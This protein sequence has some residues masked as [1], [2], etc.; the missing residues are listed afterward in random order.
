MIPGQASHVSAQE[1]SGRCKEKGRTMRIRKGE[2]ICMPTSLE[3][4]YFLNLISRIV[5]QCKL[6]ISTAVASRARMRELT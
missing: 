4:L 5:L 3:V 6:H 2:Y 1:H